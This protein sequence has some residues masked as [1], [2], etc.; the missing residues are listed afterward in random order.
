[1][2]TILPANLT[3]QIVLVIG[4]H[5]AAPWML[6]LTARLS[7]QSRVRVLDAGNR[8]NVYPLAR[9]IRRYQHNP[10][11]ALERIHLSRAFTCYQVDTALKEW[12]QADP[13]LLVFDLLATFYDENVCFAES[14][15]LLR[16]VIDRLIQFSQKIPVVISTS[17][18]AAVCA[19]RLVLVEL[20]KEQA[21]ETRYELP[22]EV[23]PAARQLSF[24]S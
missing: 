19:E 7:L 2:H 13:I 9:W 23:A 21:A 1:M 15:R 17:L 4:E 18:P 10:Y 14:Q 8:F 12:Q 22:R 24:L 6:A 11:P 20:L 3:N 16:L 5:A